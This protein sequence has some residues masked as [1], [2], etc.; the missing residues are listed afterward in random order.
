MVAFVRICVVSGEK[1]LVCL[2]VRIFFLSC[3]IITKE[4]TQ[5]FHVLFIV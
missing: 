2:F 3:E 1:R 5:V 4:K